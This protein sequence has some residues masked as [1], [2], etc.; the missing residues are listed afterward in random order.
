MR[1]RLNE[2]SAQERDVLIYITTHGK[3]KPG[4]TKEKI[5]WAG[6]R[7]DILEQ[8]L[9]NELLREINGRFQIVPDSFLCADVPESISETDLVG[10]TTS[11][12]DSLNS[13]DTIGIQP[14]VGFLFMSEPSKEKV[15][16]LA[17][18]H[19]QE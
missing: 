11:G 8:L 9:E 17:I 2:L 1:Y 18:P 12:I 6:L 3:N 10:T 14:G 16:A 4:P 7:G 5:L 13:M 19:L 15:N